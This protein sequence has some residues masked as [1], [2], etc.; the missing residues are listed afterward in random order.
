[1]DFPKS[2][3]IDTCE[4]FL[5]ALEAHEVVEPLQLPVGTSGYASSF[6]G[7]ASAIQAANSWV[8]FDQDRLLTVRPSKSCDELD[9][10][11]RKPHKFVAAMSS[12]GIFRKGE[13]DVKLRPEVN[14]AAK[15][16]IENQANQQ[17][18]QQHGRLCWFGFVDHSSKGFD[19]NFYIE[20]QGTNPEPRQP[21]QIKAV[22]RAMVEKSIGVAGG[23]RQLERDSVDYLGRVFYE[24]FLNTHE[25][26][27]RGSSRSEWL[28][29]G[30]RVIYVQGI[31]LNGSGN[32]KFAKNQPVLSGY[33]QS[34]ANK[35]ALNGRKRFV[36]IGIVDSGLG[37]YRRWLADHPSSVL[38]ENPSITEEYEI[39]RKCFSFR[40]TSTT[41]GSK[42]NGLPAVMDR[43]TRLDGFMRVR[44]GRLS[45][46][47]DFV[48][49]PY[50]PDDECAFSDWRSGQIAGPTLTPMPQS[51][52]V[53]ITLLVPV[54][55]K[56]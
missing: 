1:M 20:K 32:A 48:S 23:G 12:K 29:P 46:Y 18:G 51:A 19:R 52:G 53:A 40:Q 25:H 16:A 21:D 22:I 4:E 26:G 14:L 44:S 33:L 43:L 49:S 56:Q 8:R 34:V 3:D 15:N 55:A 11:I 9:E 6:G 7:L 54:E 37:Y 2:I 10:L 39:F 47:R 42:G 36:E 24:L 41:S 38:N 17:F 50:A 27:T 28:R 35:N 45:L 5:E 31:N 13:P 30:V